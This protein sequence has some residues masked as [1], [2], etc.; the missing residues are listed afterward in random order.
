MKYALLIFV[1][2]L[3]LWAWKKPKKSVPDFGYQKQFKWLE[4]E[5]VVFKIP[6]YL[7]SLPPANSNL[8]TFFQ[9]PRL[10]TVMISDQKRLVLQNP[11][12]EA[13]VFSPSFWPNFQPS[14]KAPS[15]S[16]FA[17]VATAEVLE[18]CLPDSSAGFELHVPVEFRIFLKEH[19]FL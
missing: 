10:I 12:G 14:A 5:G 6:A 7:R 3:V 4:H 13:F 11:S 8:P 17:R 9:E 2:L 18:V 16:V 19:K 15:L 1:I